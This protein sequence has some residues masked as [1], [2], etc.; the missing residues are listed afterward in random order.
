[1]S[2]RLIPISS[3]P[4]P[5]RTSSIGP[6]C[7]TSI[8]IER[9]SSLPERTWAR[10]LSRV[11]SREASGDTSSRVPLTKASPGPAG[12]QQVEEPLLGQ[13]LG[14]LA[15]R[16]R[17]LRLDH[18]HAELGQ[19]ADHGLHV[20][21]HVADLGVLGRLHLEERSLGELGEAAGDLGLPDPGGSDHDDVLGRHL[22]PQ[23][24]GQVLPPPPVAQRDGHRALG[25]TLPHDEA[26]QLGGDLGRREPGHLERLAELSGR[27]VGHR[28]STV[29]WSFV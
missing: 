8:S 29:I 26:V 28:L 5:G 11:A 25:L 19:V 18:A 7:C 16:R 13:R 15:H 23:L 6:A 10:S 20:A 21:A 9:S 3:M 22:V 12:Q 14:P 2:F 1:M 24:R 4:W 27:L 17:H